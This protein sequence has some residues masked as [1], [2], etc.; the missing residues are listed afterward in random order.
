MRNLMACLLTLFL[1]GGSATAATLNFALNTGGGS[2]AVIDTS[3]PAGFFTTSFAMTGS[4]TGTLGSVVT[5]YSAN[6]GDTGY[7]VTGEYA[8]LT[9]DINGPFYDPFGFVKGGVLTQLTDSSG[10]AAQTGTFSFFVG[11]GSSF[12]WYID[13]VDDQLGAGMVSVGANIT[14]VPL[15][16]GVWLLLGA[17]GVMGAMRRRPTAAP[18]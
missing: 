11:K 5:D 17:I 3:N 18:V 12:G 10:S 6:T 14:A 16:A 8:F 2:G 13:A 15:P 4:D 7:Q 1:A 9:A